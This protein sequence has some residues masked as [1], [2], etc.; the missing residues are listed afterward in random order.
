MKRAC[1]K[2]SGTFVHLF[3]TRQSVS[4]QSSIVVVQSNVSVFP[5]PPASQF[6]RSLQH[7]SSRTRSHHSIQGRR[8]GEAHCFGCLWRMWTG[9]L[10][11]ETLAM[12][13]QCVPD[14][15][16]V[17]L[18]S[19]LARRHS[20]SSSSAQSSKVFPRS[21]DT[22][23]SMIFSKTRLHSFTPFHRRRIL[24]LNIRIYREALP[25]QPQLGA[26]LPPTPHHPLQPP[27]HSAQVR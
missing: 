6:T 22:E 18:L 13:D 16:T 27:L 15:C 9:E 20:T 26:H 2:R 17:S 19:Q 4:V 8:S 7:A 10:S 11:N 24:L 1:S 14:S 5:L 23:R 25:Q 21:R 12:N 3:P